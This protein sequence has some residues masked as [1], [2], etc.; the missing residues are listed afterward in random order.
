MNQNELFEEQVRKDLHQYLVMMGKAD[1]HFPEAPDIEEKWDEI[2]KEYIPDGVREFNDYPTVS[3]GWIMYVGMAV[4]KLWDCDWAYY[5]TLPNLY[6]HLRD[7][8]GFDTMDEYIR[9]EVLELTD[10]PTPASALTPFAAA[11]K[12]VAECASRTYNR[13]CHAPFENGTK[14]SFN[15]YVSCLHQLYLMGAA[16]QLKEMGYKMTKI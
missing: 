12:L 7:K 16:M 14:E 9:E 6:T 2:L 1:E 5:S 3:L 11:E 13:F 10:T 15:G 8:R 4:A